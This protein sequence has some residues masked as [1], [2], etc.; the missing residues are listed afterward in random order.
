MR[1]PDILWGKGGFPLGRFIKY[2][3]IGSL[4]DI[5]PNARAEFENGIIYHP[6]YNNVTHIDEF[7][8]KIM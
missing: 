2:I 8:K 5:M 4:G 1:E 3:D 7:L 6:Y